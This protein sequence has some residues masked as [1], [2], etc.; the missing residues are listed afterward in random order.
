[1]TNVGT[2]KTTEAVTIRT[3]AVIVAVVAVL[4]ILLA[5]LPWRWPHF[6]VPGLL[7][8]CRPL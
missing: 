4:V 5:A 3:L 6:R 2:E 1:M 7:H 8:Q